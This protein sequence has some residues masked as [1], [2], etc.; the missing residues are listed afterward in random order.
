M[1]RFTLCW[2]GNYATD[3]QNPSEDQDDD[4]ASVQPI[5][6]ATHAH[7]YPTLPVFMHT[8]EGVAQDVDWASQ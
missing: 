6:P 2:K 4:E 1:L 7:Q 8:T 5:T 3:I